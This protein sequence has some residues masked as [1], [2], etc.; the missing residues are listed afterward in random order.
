M[1]KNVRI[2]CA[3]WG[4]SILLSRLVSMVREGAIGRIL[5]ASAASDVYNA[6]F[7]LPDFLNYLLAAGAL[8]IVFIPI[9]GGYLARGALAGEEDAPIPAHP[10]LRRRRRTCEGPGLHL[11]R[12]R[13]VPVPYSDTVFL[14]CGLARC[15]GP[16]STG[17]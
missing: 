8:S 4:T 13:I 17:R 6:S 3:V 11:D 1:S 10:G 9:F 7:Q 16:F 15:D 14:G 5:G 12:G 2:A